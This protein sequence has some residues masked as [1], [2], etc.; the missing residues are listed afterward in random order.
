MKDK[1]EIIVTT[2]LGI[3]AFTAKELRKLGYADVKVEDGRVAFWGGYEDV[4]R[5]NLWLRTGERVLI[6]AGEFLA[7]SFEELFEN[8]YS[9]DWERFLQ[10]NSAFPVKGYSVKSQ[11]SSIPDCQSIIKK[12]IAKK[13]GL[14]F[15]VSWL[16][17]DGSEYKIQFSIMKNKVTIMIDTSGEALHKRGYRQFSNAA[18]LRE[19]IAAAMVMMSYWKFEYPLLDPFCGSGTIP[20]EGAMFKRNIAPG[21]NRTFA[22]DSFLQLSVS[23]KNRLIDEAKAMQK[24]IN[25]EIYASDI[26]LECVKL[27]RN[28]ALKAGVSDFINVSHKKAEDVYINKPYGTIICNPPYGERMGNMKEC[29]ILYR[30]LGNSFTNLDNWNYYILT[31][32]E[33]FE[34]FFGKKADKKRKIYNGMIKC[35]IYQYFGERPPKFIQEGKVGNGKRI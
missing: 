33:D 5:A 15:G 32:N 29:E 8:V 1:F 24:D 27:T 13:L 28:N 9:I 22:V 23:E 10:R 35:N 31:A 6:K 7:Q 18:P 16:P 25:L 26:D 20:I 2:L 30:N 19:T 14:I 4:Y 12:A 3:E 17:E 34:K 21:I 11:L